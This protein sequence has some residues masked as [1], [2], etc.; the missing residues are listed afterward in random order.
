MRLADVE[1][2]GRADL[3][4][5]DKYTG[6]VTVFKNNGRSSSGSSSFSWTNRGK[7]YN[8]INSGETMIF[9][10]QGGLY[11]ADMVHVDPATNK[12]WTYFNKCGNSSG[13]DGTICKRHTIDF[14]LYGCFN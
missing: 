12:A 10:N 6:A 7:L 5:V 8:P 9:T 11:R 14:V 2:S 13:D 3:L 1:A 4:H